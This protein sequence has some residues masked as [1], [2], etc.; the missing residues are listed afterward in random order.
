MTYIVTSLNFTSNFAFFF[1]TLILNIFQNGN[2]WTLLY[3]YKNYQE[4]VELPKYA[5]NHTKKELRNDVID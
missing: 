5:P 1:F 4:K 2:F 3:E